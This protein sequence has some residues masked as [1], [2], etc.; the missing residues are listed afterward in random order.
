MC[1][2]HCHHRKQRFPEF[3]FGLKC[4]DWGAFGDFVCLQANGRIGEDMTVGFCLGLQPYSYLAWWL[5]KKMVAKF[6]DCKRR[7]NHLVS[8]CSLY[9][10]VGVTDEFSRHVFPSPCFCC[11]WN[12]TVPLNV[13]LII[14]SSIFNVVNQV[15]KL[16][17]SSITHLLI[18]KISY[19][20]FYCLE[21]WKRIRKKKS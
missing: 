21:F 20:L 18:I 6:Q 8:G 3:C 12:R 5:I 11:P 17:S 2:S 1:I 16:K 10:R 15:G 13:N 14:S 4:W 19:H 7:K 9:Y